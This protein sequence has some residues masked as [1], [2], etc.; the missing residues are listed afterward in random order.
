MP[1][2]AEVFFY[3]HQWR[4]AI[5]EM[6][7][8]VHTHPRKRIFRDCPA[9]SLAGLQGRTLR[10]FRTHGKQMAFR[11]D[12]DLWLGLHLGM[13]GKL[14]S[15]PPEWVPDTHDHLILY[16]NRHA[17]VFNDYRQFGK[18]LLGSQRGHPPQW[19]SL[20]P[21]PHDPLFDFRHFSALLHSAPRRSLKGRLLDQ[22]A[23]PGIGNW[24]ADEIL[25]RARLHPA[26]VP[27][28]L[29][30]PQRRTLFAK[31]KEVCEDALR[32]IGSSWGDPP[33]SWLFQHRWKKGGRC[34]VSGKPLQ[35]ETIA[36]RTTCFS[37]AL[38][39]EGPP[40]SAKDT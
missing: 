10:E 8:R 23:F 18:V 11:F 22:G 31:V 2:L 28:E 14:L 36:G 21:Q 7:H 12:D 1:E 15:G 35:Y 20:P 30:A 38:Q 24:M 3:A 16:T 33:P 4:A 34:P 25:W 32:V 29:T 9:A 27:A 5:G 40:A 13:A 26:A 39:K 37:P 19:P 17:L 6:V